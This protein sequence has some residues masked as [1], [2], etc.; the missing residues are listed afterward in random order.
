MDIVLYLLVG[1]LMYKIL[2]RKTTTIIKLEKPA[3][4]EIHIRIEEIGTQIYLWDNKTEDFLSQ[5]K[6][7]DEAIDKCV[8]RFK[9]YPGLKFTIN[10]E[11]MVK[12]E[13]KPRQS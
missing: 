2:Q 10:K 12:Y 11:D 4:K 6:N 5:G 13:I 8:D 3:L 1:Y 9:I 7:I